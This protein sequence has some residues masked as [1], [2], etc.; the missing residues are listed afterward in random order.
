MG[1][2]D[3]FFAENAFGGCHPLIRCSSEPFRGTCALSRVYLCAS[4]ITL[5]ASSS[6][7]SLHFYAAFI[8]WSTWPLTLTCHDDIYIYAASIYWSSCRYPL[9]CDLSLCASRSMFTSTLAPSTGAPP[10]GYGV[11]LLVRVEQYIVGYHYIVSV[12]FVEYI[13]CIPFSAAPSHFSA[14][15]YLLEHLVIPVQWLSRSSLAPRGIHFRH[16]LPCLP[17]HIYAASSFQHSHHSFSFT[18][19]CALRG[20][21]CRHPLHTYL[22]ISTPPSSTGAPG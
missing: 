22:C 15:I 3:A 7:L 6:R 20:V 1:S 14:S 17:V 12:R 19:T 21:H 18:S 16:A 8:Y 11:I 13:F 5:S 4:R 9:P 2:S 10:H